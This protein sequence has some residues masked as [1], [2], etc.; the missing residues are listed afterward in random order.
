MRPT[1][2]RDVQDILRAINADAASGRRHIAVHPVSTG[3]NWGLGSRD[4]SSDGAVLLDLSGL[5]RIRQIDH[6]VG[7][8]VV[9]PGVTQHQLA[10]RLR[11]TGSMLNFTASSPHTSIVGNAVERGVGVRR[12]RC[13][14][15]VGLE[16][17]LPDGRLLRLGNWPHDEQP[18]TPY[19]Y[20][21]GPGLM[22]LFFQ[23]NLG[24]VTAAVVALLPRPEALELVCLRFER[25]ALGAATDLL[26]AWCTQGGTRGTVKVFLDA[27]RVS[28]TGTGTE[29]AAYIAVDG[30]AEVVDALTGILCRRASTTGAFSSIYRIAGP[31]APD[32]PLGHRLHRAHLGEVSPA[33]EMTREIFG[34]PASD[35]DRSG[36]TGWLFY[37]PVL[38]FD[39]T[40]LTTARDILDGV[41][42]ETG[43]DCRATANVI[44]VDVVDLVVSLRFAR[45]DPDVHRAHRALA[46]MHDR[47]PAAGF[48]PYRID[49]DH[50]DRWPSLLVDP[51]AADLLMEIKARLDPFEVVSPGR[52]V[53]TT[54]DR[55]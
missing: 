36:S 43:T 6:R 53:P 23:S 20:E 16:V 47:F 12:Q 24:V 7:V 19:R 48:R 38:P 1:S 51:A 31:G 28:T 46:L 25:Q 22:P 45:R 44:G 42:A 21:L 9:E 55:R 37:L 34:T 18:A 50:M 54:H 30:H 52:Y 5:D 39:R 10:E 35:V 13:E 49:I 33:D 4:P 26:R 8:A 41:R 29:C 3:H 27:A 40:S 14:D 15:V 2:V 32:D 17:V 11:G